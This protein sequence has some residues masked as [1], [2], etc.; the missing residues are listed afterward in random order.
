MIYA[1]FNDCLPLNLAVRLYSQALEKIARGFKRLHDNLSDCDNILG[2]II[3]NSEKSQYILDGNKL[4]LEQCIKD[5][6]DRD[7]RNL[8]VSWMSNYPE[9]AF[10]KK[11]VDDVAILCEEFHM[12]YGVDKQNAINLIL[13]KQ[14]DAFLISLNLHELLGVN[15]VNVQGTNQNVLVDN[16]YGEDDSNVEFI[17]NVV[18]NTIE[19]DLDTSQQIEAILKNPIKHKAYD[20]EYSKLTSVEQKA[21]LETWKDANAK[22]LLNPFKPDN[23]VVKKTE[24]PVK[25]ES[26]IGP[27]YEL[28]VRKPREIRVYFQFVNNTYFLL[29]IG[30]KTH[31]DIDIKNAF[32]KAKSLRSKI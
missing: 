11:S 7:I 14:N 3:T 2:G 17:T 27:V 28:R 23:I 12:T 5:I 20:T 25:Q 24:G 16:L 4:T 30:D 1:Y 19:K 13:A 32:S 22:H 31:Q 18:R 21:I 8:L 15:Q 9:N 29:D 10:F 6:Y 26:L